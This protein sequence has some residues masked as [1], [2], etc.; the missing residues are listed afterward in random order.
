MHRLVLLVSFVAA[1]ATSETPEP[2]PTPPSYEDDEKADA[3][4]ESRLVGTKNEWGE[5][6]R[7]DEAAV[8]AGLATKINE[9]QRILSVNG[10]AKRGFHAKMHGCMKAEFRLNANR[11]AETRVGAF[12]DDAP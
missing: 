8:F 11:P 12:A 7:P 1:C 5:I 10:I 2:E 3:A 6:I 9:L 4:F